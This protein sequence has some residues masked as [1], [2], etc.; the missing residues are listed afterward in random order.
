[1]AGTWHFVGFSRRFPRNKPVSA[2]H[3][4]IPV[5][6]WRTHEKLLALRD[7]CPHR[8]FPM[9]EG[10]VCGEGKLH[11]A[12]HGWTF[13]RERQ[14]LERPG[15][16]ESCPPE[17][18]L[19][20]FPVKE[21]AGCVFVGESESSEIPRWLSDLDDPGMDS[22]ALENSIAAGL[23]DVLENVLDP[24][25]THY[26]HGAFLRSNHTRHMVNVKATDSSGQRILAMEFFNEPRPTGWVSR[27]LED[28]RL[29]T[30]G[31]YVGPNVAVLEYWTN[32]GF[33]LRVTMA[34]SKLGELSTTGVVIFQTARQGWFHSVKR[35]V[36]RLFAEHLMEQDKRAL[37]VLAANQ[38][39]FPNAGPW[40]GK[41]D[42]V[43]DT[44]RSLHRG[45]GLDSFERE[46]EMRL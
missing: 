13:S 6:I 15:I 2:R 41:E 45:Q 16:A 24:F 27:L 1:M 17:A 43:L 38:A 39:R 3:G 40:I 33:A 32:Q 20:G 18:R 46:L 8:G 19:S 29:K 36:L 44:I 25:H 23:P 35:A 26:L 12:Y 21:T 14:L 11:C 30:L 28:A 9:N 4:V 37:E 7:R 31:R 42:I 5:V 34:L 10:F 22:F